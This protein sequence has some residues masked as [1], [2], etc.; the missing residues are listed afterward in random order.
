MTEN[1]KSLE[2]FTEKKPNL[3]LFSKKDQIFNINLFK[4]KAK[5]RGLLD[6]KMETDF[7]FK[8]VNR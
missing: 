5:E 4:G 6:Q 1:L 7:R 2:N 8:D 3:E